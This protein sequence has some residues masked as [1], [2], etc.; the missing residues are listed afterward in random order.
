MGGVDNGRGGQTGPPS[1]PYDIGAA[2]LRP[3]QLV[4]G[5]VDP[6]P[7]GPD[8]PGGVVGAALRYA[9]VRWWSWVRIKKKKKKKYFP[10]YYI[11]LRPR[12]SRLFTENFF[13]KF[14]VKL[15]HFGKKFDIIYI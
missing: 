1:T 7:C 10:F 14:C 12:L 4:P 2:E 9:W 15:L 3:H 6:R 11:I 13:K 8:T 5:A